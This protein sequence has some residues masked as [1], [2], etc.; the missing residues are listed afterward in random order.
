MHSIATSSSCAA[1]VLTTAAAQPAP[2]Q[3]HVPAGQPA[4]AALHMT[5]LSP[6][7]VASAIFCFMHA[8]LQSPLHPF[9]ATHDTSRPQIKAGRSLCGDSWAS[10]HQLQVHQCNTQQRGWWLFWFS[11]VL[12]SWRARLASLPCSAMAILSAQLQSAEP[13]IPARAPAAAACSC[14]P[15][16]LWRQRRASAAA[17]PAAPWRAAC[18]APQAQHASRCAAGTAYCL[19]LSGQ[20]TAGSRLLTT[21]A[22]AT[23]GTE[24]KGTCDGKA[25]SQDR[26][27]AAT[28]A[29]QHLA[30]ILGGTCSAQLDRQGRSSP[31][32]EGCRRRQLES[33]RRAHSLV[34]QKEVVL[35]TTHRGQQDVESN[36]PKTTTKS[37]TK[38]MFQTTHRKQQGVEGGSWKAFA[39]LT[40][41]Q[42]ETVWHA[43]HRKQQDVESN[44][45]KTTAKLY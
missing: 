11:T 30:C 9:H 35:H 18:C 10:S 39:E 28:Q 6:P 31:R 42:Q 22:P 37:H 32:A 3:P 20:Q 1:R 40:L 17:E 12:H 33:I 19:A 41:R 27:L 16:R 45:Q 34:R 2:L 4:G 13:G 8:A 7:F 44:A 21:A 26:K 38:N 29:Q 15:V 36:A 25:V 5:P 43:T 24:A 23:S 14:Q